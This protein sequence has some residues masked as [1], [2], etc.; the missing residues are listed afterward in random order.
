MRTIR[1]DRHIFLDWRIMGNLIWVTTRKRRKRMCQTCK[2]VVEQQKSCFLLCSQAHHLI[3]ITRHCGDKFN[4]VGSIKVFRFLDIEDFYF[5]RKVCPWSGKR[6]TVT[7]RVQVTIVC[8]KNARWSIVTLCIEKVTRWYPEC[9]VGTRSRY[10]AWSW[11]AKPKIGEMVAEESSTLVDSRIF[12]D[13]RNEAQLRYSSLHRKM[14]SFMQQTED[15]KKNPDSKYD[16]LIYKQNC[17]NDSVA[18]QLNEAKEKLA[19]LTHSLKSIQVCGK[20]NQLSIISRKQL[21]KSPWNCRLPAQLKGFDPQ[22]RLHVKSEFEFLPFGVLSISF[23]PLENRRTK[24]WRKSNDS[25]ACK[26]IWSRAW[27]VCSLKLITSQRWDLK[28]LSSSF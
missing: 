1:H 11:R 23:L 18:L 16:S 2:L 7:V 25:N 13:L 24:F 9:S 12:L 26:L 6:V 19:V 20:G 27:T 15:T 10:S 4:F 8:C 3:S 21:T 14:E 22:L 17:V 5:R 28:K